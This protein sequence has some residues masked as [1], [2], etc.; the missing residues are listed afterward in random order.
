MA[1]TKACLTCPQYQNMIWPE[2]ASIMPNIHPT[3]KT[4]EKY[5]KDGKII[6]RIIEE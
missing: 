4:T 5:D 3:R 6:E 2:Q 1:G